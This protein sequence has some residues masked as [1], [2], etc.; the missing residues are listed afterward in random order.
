MNLRR[1]RYGEWIAGVSGIALL[2]ALFLD[3]YSFSGVAANAWQALSVIDVFLALAAVLGIALMLTTATQRSAAV[4]QATGAIA[5]PFAFVASVLVLIRAISLPGGADGRELGLFLGIA[6]TLGVLIGAWRS[7]G[8]DRFPA[9]A[10][11]AVEVTP[12]PA[13]Q[14][15]SE[16]E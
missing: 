6:A 15:R 11:P 9:G 14:P 1:L 3:W 10:S 13:P 12:L 2:V 5:V 4:P 7:I 16:P 8:D